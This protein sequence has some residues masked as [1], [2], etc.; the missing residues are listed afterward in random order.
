M[1]S[2]RKI[3]TYIY[4]DVHKR[5]PKI[6]DAK[7]AIYCK[8]ERE[9]RASVR[10]WL[11]SENTHMVCV[12]VSSRENIYIQHNNAPK[13]YILNIMR[14]QLQWVHHVGFTMSI[15]KGW[16]I[17]K[18]ALMKFWLGRE[19]NN[20]LTNSKCVCVHTIS[21]KNPPVFFSQE[22]VF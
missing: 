7:W 2:I 20:M 16:E 4:I 15:Y 17:K 6:A 10:V 18:K 14:W 13:I 22:T 12:R 8:S 19:K 1:E 5:D 9:K 11:S 21:R 3:R